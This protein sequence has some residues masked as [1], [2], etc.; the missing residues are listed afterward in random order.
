V[1]QELEA[2]VAA[3]GQKSPPGLRRDGATV[4]QGRNILHKSGPNMIAADK[5]MKEGRQLHRRR[6]TDNKGPAK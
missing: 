2:A 1:W 3:A 6:E 4:T 5:A